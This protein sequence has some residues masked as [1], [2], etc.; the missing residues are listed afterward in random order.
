MNL[1]NE[2]IVGELNLLLFNIPEDMTPIEQVRWLYLKAGRLFSYDYR[3]AYDPSIVERRPDYENNYVGRYQTCAQISEIFNTMLNYIDGV[4][5]KVIER[6]MDFRGHA[7]LGLEHQANEVTVDG[8]TFILDLTLDLYLIQSGYKTMHFGYESSPVKDYDILIDSDYIKV[9]EEL[10]ITKNKKNVMESL[11]DEVKE[12][13][14][15][16]DYSNM[17]P[18]GVIDS[19]LKNIY[20]LIPEF[21]G[22]HEGKRFINK[23]FSDLLKMDYREFNLVYQK[24]EFGGLVTC[25]VIYYQG[26]ER[27][28]LY[29]NATGLS[30]TSKEKIEKM[31]NNGWRTKSNTLNNLFKTK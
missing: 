31:L 11:E 17:T 2:N 24:E 14:D 5:S 8:L 1:E 10:G 12:I 30:K 21:K 4:S 20:G 26:V 13:I 19:K 6:K 7:T 3:V 16:T 15:E 29:S 22:H 18:L 28:L 9:D 25:F 27:W 23:L